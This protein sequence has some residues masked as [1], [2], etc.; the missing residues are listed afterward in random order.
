MSHFYQFFFATK[1][2]NPPRRRKKTRKKNCSGR[3]GGGFLMQFRINVAT[4]RKAARQLGR[5][6]TPFHG[7]GGGRQKYS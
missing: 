1:K 3:W 4:N 7:E 5:R 6:A 2:K